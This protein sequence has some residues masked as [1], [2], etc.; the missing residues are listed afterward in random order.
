MQILCVL[1]RPRVNSKIVFDLSYELKA[2]LE[3][4][5]SKHCND[6]FTAHPVGN[7]NPRKSCEKRKIHDRRELRLFKGE[8]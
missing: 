4:L 6:N 2:E 3:S 5:R 1:P 7:F 8:F